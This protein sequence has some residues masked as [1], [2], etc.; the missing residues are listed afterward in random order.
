MRGQ[1]QMEDTEWMC[2]KC[3]LPLESRR[4]D[5]AYLGNVFVI[6]L[7]TCP[8]CGLVVVTEEIATGKM[9]EAEQILEDK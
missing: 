3:G 1:K 2:A 5:V 8:K 9:M 6:D 4:T 7:P